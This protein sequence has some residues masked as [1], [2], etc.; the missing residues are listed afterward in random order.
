MSGWFKVHRE[1]YDKPIWVTST[2]EQK[3]ILMTLLSMANFEPKEW[4]WK[5]QRYKVQPGQFITSLPSIAE[6]CGKG[7]SIQNVR[8]ALKRFEKYD[9]L[10]DESTK[11]NRLITIANWSIYQG[12]EKPIEEDQQANQQTANSQLTDDQQT[13]NSQLTA[14]KNLRT[15]EL[16][17]DKEIK[18]KKSSSKKHFEPESPEMVLADFFVSEIRKNKPDF[19]EPNLQGWAEDF[20]KILDLDKRD[21]SEVSRLIR[22]VQQDDFEMVNVLSPSKLRTRYDNLAMK[23]NKT[24]K[25]MNNYA[26]ATKGSVGPSVEEYDGLS[27]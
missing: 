15:K 16:K 14:S 24:L 13:A 7:V 10:T 4:E 26:A 17:N 3:V 1:L 19:K 23:M 8:T 12:L 20:R 5:G 9:F 6:K 11:Q 22:W 2:P 21:K 27:L 25:G 18:K